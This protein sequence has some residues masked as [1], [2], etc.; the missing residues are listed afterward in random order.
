MN[1]RYGC[2]LTD[3]KE[4]RW[5]I[6]RFDGIN[7]P[8]VF[9]RTLLRDGEGWFENYCLYD[10]ALFVKEADE[11]LDALAEGEKRK[12]NTL[13]KRYVREDGAVC[14]NVGPVMLDDFIPDDWYDAW[15]QM[16]SVITSSADYTG[17]YEDEVSTEIFY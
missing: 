6:A 4:Y 13:L 7:H 8:L 15:K 5:I 16:E 12:A 2:I 11:I 10:K 17:F 9:V 1:L 3:H 14:E